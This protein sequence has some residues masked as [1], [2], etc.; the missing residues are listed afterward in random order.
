V[1][2]A[3]TVCYPAEILTRKFQVN[4]LLSKNRDQGSKREKQEEK[5]AEN[6]IMRS[7]IMCTVHWQLEWSDEGE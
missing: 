5:N 3:R 4:R 1:K 7:F 2:E 6:C